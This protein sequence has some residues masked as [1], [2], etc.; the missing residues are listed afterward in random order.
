F[1]LVI[2]GMIWLAAETDFEVIWREGLLISAMMLVVY[3]LLRWN[4]FFTTEIKRGIFADLD[5]TLND[6]VEL[7]AVLLL[8][9]TLLWMNVFWIG[10]SLLQNISQFKNPNLRWVYLRDTVMGFASNI[11]IAL[12]AL[13]VY[14]L[15]GGSYPM[16]TLTWEA[17][18][19]AVVMV[20]VLMA[21]TTLLYTPLILYWASSAVLGGTADSRVAFV[22]FFVTSMGWRIVVFPFAILAAGVYAYSGAVGYFFLMAGVLLSSGVAHHMSIAVERNRRRTTELERLERLSRAILNSKPDVA[23]LYKVLREHVPGMFTYSH[24]EIRLFPNELLLAYP[25]SSPPMPPEAWYWIRKTTASHFFMP[26][27][28]VPW[29]VGVISHALIV[30]PV[31]DTETNEVLGGIFLQISKSILRRGA[32]SIENIIPAVQS[33]AGQIASAL[34]R[35]KEHARA[36]AAQR[37]SQELMLA[38]QIQSAFL[39]QNVPEILGWQLT[40]ILEPARQTSGD[41]YDLIPLPGGKLG[42]VVADV[43]D[44]GMGA[45]LFMALSR[46]LIRVY[47]G[48][49]PDHPNLTLEAANRRIMLDTHSDMFVTVFFGILDPLTS[50]FVYC[51]AGHNPAFFVSS[52]EI[53]PLK[54]TGVPLGLFEKTTWQC[55]SVLF[56]PGDMLVMY[57]DGLIE[58]VNRQ[59]E[60]FEEYRL[61]DL[62]QVQRG[63]PARAV[64]S[65][66]IRAAYQFMGDVPLADDLTLIVVVKE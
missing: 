64:H 29:N 3:F 57:T 61:I 45:A 65:A 5:G 26:D 51:N 25:E 7:S 34:N 59:E 56:T 14:E 53:K 47:A 11:T 12:M 21:L 54:R 8:G 37:M 62:L 32:D 66:I 27:R 58:A 28:V 9:P 48:E 4:F 35:V 40:A 23:S 46:T 52:Q 10:F 15:L 24:I 44:K 19:P 63:R 20:L 17:A 33:L 49:F 22:N 13:W 50:T 6:I 60:M 16:G 36:L 39:P 38:G 43:A 30:T 18:L 55:E 41:F 42:I 31:L 1:P 2:L